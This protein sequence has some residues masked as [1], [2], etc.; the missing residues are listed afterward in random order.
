[1]SVIYDRLTE[2][3]NSEAY[4]FHMPGHKRHLKGD[5]LNDITGIDITEIE[6]FDN[7]HDAQD[8]ILEAQQK[9]A[10]V[11]GAEE[12]FFLVNGSTCGILSAVA[13]CVK[14]GGWLMM[15]RNCHKAVYH[16]ALLGQLNTIYMY[17]DVKEG[18]S[19]VD[20]FGVDT[21]KREVEQ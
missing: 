14:T 3:C 13:T 9:A 2:Y 20:G 7:L 1:M 4:P 6:G 19:F 11:Y 10:S 17:P 16:A 21:I 12:S 18:F 15:G 5:I 8:L